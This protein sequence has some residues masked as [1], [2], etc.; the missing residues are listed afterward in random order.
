MHYLIF[1]SKYEVINE[2]S[3]A[4]T[5][6]YFNSQFNHNHNLHQVEMI[7]MVATHETAETNYFQ[8]IFFNFAQLVDT[9]YEM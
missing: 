7:K 4:C 1:L 8:V 9:L 6:I 5:L 2:K 3:N